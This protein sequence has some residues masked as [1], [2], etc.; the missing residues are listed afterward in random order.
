MCQCLLTA[1]AWVSLATPDY[2]NIGRN[3]QGI[4]IWPLLNGLTDTILEQSLVWVQHGTHTH[5]TVGWLPPPN[6]TSP[7][8]GS[9]CPIPNKVTP[10]P[11]HT[12]QP[13]THSLRWSQLTV[14]YCARAAHS[15]VHR[16]YVPCW[17]SLQM[18]C[19]VLHATE[20]KTS[21]WLNL[22]VPFHQRGGVWWEGGGGKGDSWG[23]LWRKGD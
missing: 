5:H 13:P 23:R 15:S 3:R 19:W 18:N 2:S 8:P 16:W 7:T 1:S 21:V 4:P 22:L 9:W 6:G 12:T 20:A 10:D 17:E 14:V 11:A